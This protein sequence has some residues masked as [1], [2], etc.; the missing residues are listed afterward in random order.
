MRTKL[1]LIAL[2]GAVTLLAGS[3]TLRPSTANAAAP[4]TAGA[5]VC[6]NNSCYGQPLCRYDLGW[7]CYLEPA[8]CAGNVLCGET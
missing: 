6:G 7:E 1:K 2:L 4:A 3:L 8:G 5:R